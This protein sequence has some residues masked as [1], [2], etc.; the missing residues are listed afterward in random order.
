[1]LYYLDGKQKFKNSKY[2][3][4]CYLPSGSPISDIS[5]SKG[6]PATASVNASDIVLAT[7]T[8]VVLKKVILNKNEIEEQK[9][10]KIAR[11]CI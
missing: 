9:N 4:V 8:S 2:K 3:R 1:M 7:L 11:V 5:K 6:V 10:Q